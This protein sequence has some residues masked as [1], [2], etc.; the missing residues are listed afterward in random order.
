MSNGSQSDQQAEPAGAQRDHVGGPV[1]PEAV[2]AEAHA[3]GADDAVAVED[4][5]VELVEDGAGED[6][7]EGHETPV[8]AQAVDAE[9]LGHDGGEDAEQEPVAEPGEAGDGP[10]EV[11][12]RDGEGKG[13]GDAEDAACYD[14]A[15][16]AAGVEHFYEKIGSDA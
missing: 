9:R 13:L 5:A 12:I 8:L 2:G 7:A 11:G 10:Q 15:P 6:G 1:T 16:D 4:H 3:V 14:Q